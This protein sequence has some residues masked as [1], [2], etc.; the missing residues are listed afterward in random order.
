MTFKEEQLTIDPVNQ[1]NLYGYENYFQAFIKLNVAKKLPQALLLSGPKGIGKSTFLYHFI[2]YLLSDTEKNKYSLKNFTI[3]EDNPSYKLIKSNSHP[4]FFLL[5]SNAPGENIKIE[6]SRDLLKYL[7]KTTYYKDIKIV[8]IDNA[9]YLNINAS[10]ALLKELEEPSEKTLFFI[11][12][13]ET[14]ILLNTVKSRCV[15]YRFHFSLDEKKSIFYKLN[16]KYDLVVDDNILDN[17][18]L[19]DSPGNLLKYLLILN[20]LKIDISQNY[21]TCINH[22][23]DAIKVKKEPELMNILALFIESFYREL[24]LKDGQNINHYFMNKNKILYLINDMNKFHLDKKNL[25]FSVTKIL[26]NERQL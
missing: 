3:N 6:Q 12:F 2:N 21:L 19:F 17:F 8:L 13:N 11:I 18:L 23:I 26:K 14:S 5:D 10:N 1:L 25:I 7:N 20:N 15:N 22:L 9:E 4:N 16:N 24:S